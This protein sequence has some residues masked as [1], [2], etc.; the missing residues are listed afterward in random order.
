MAAPDR[1]EAQPALAIVGAGRAG[2]GL[3]AAL[4]SQGYPVRSCWSL[5]EDRA[6]AVALS[7]GLH[8]YWGS[9]FPKERHWLVAISDSALEGFGATLARQDVESAVHV[10]GALSSRVLAHDDYRG[11]C[12]SLHP[13]VAIP[14]LLQVGSQRVISLLVGAHYAVEGDAQALPLAESLRA[15][16]AGR[17]LRVGTEGKALYHAGAVVASNYLVTLIELSSRLWQAAGIEEQGVSAL[18]ELARGALDN[19]ARGEQ[20]QGRGWRPIHELTGPIARGD[21]ATL[22]KHQQ[23]MKEGQ[24]AAAHQAYEALAE[25]TQELLADGVIQ[26]EVATRGRGKG[27]QQTE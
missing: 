15:C 1:L 6:Q 7:L 3:A 25:L 23:A 11:G 22:E 26:A 27:P 2:A 19:I 4:K 17:R 21:R 8:A 12:A 16:L 24:L 14:D 18:V 13:L 20:R 9:R 5:D 10:S